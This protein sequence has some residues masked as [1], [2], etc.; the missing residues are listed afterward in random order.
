MVGG[1]GLPPGGYRQLTFCQFSRQQIAEY[2]SGHNSCLDTQPI[3]LQP[4]TGLSARAASASR[5]HLSWRDNSANE[6]GFIVERRREGS[7]IWVQIGTTTADTEAFTSEGLFSE[8]TYLHRVQAF[9]DSVSSAYSNEAAA[10]T[11]AGTPIATGW[12]IDTIAGRTDDDGDNGPA[13]EARLAFP[14]DVAVDG[15]GRR[16][17]R[18]QG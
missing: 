12:R 4:P 9:I 17:H 18:R 14:D 2:L 8:A 13:I 5:I 6:T 15:S 1:G 16:L 11:P 7:G 3:P 10:T